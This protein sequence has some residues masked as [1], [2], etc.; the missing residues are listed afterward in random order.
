MIHILSSQQVAGMD[1]KI[2]FETTHTS[3]PPFGPNIEGAYF[4]ALSGD[5]ILWGFRGISFVVW[6]E[7]KQRETMTV[8]CG[9]ARRNWSF[10]CNENEAGTLIW[11][12]ASR[13]NLH[14]QRQASHK[15]I[16]EGGH[17]REIKAV[18]I[19]TPLSVSGS[20]PVSLIA[21]GA[22]DTNLRLFAFQEDDTS[23][24]GARFRPLGVFRQH[25]TGLQHLQWGGSGRFLFSSG[26]A[27]EF[28]I[29]KVR[30]DSGLPVCMTCEAAIPATGEH[31]DVRVMNFHVLDLPEKK[32]AIGLQA[33]FLLCIVYSNS[34]IRVSF[35]DLVVPFT[36][37]T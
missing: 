37:L 20:G 3:T 12:K 26:G 17:G 35:H 31:T 6:N 16:Q 33:R 1:V 9:G 32:G 22:E 28:F 23:L 18:A 25:T 11:T 36:L 14:R 7:T 24:K 5:L 29:W 10:I 21:T 4:Q 13:L 15:V 30:S 2:C 19:S 8:E 34:T 27:E